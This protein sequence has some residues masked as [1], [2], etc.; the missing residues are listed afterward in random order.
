M[1]SYTWSAVVKKQLI[2]STLL[3]EG[4]ISRILEDYLSKVHL[5]NLIQLEA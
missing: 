3:F 2:Y 1:F 4:I 5:I